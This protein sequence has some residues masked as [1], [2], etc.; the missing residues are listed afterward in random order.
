VLAGGV[1]ADWLDGPG[2]VVKGLRTPHGPLS[3]S[4]RSESGR[5]VLRIAGGSRVPPGGLVLAWPGR[6]PPPRDTRIN[7]KPAQWRGTEL[8]IHELP[9]HVVIHGTP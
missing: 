6:R 3:F 4:L 2:V 7:G 8:A 5:V 9:A 1:P